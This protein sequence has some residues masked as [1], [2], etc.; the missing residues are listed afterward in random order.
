MDQQPLSS[1]WS[2]IASVAIVVFPVV[3]TVL[4]IFLV[5]RRIRAD[6]ERNA[7]KCAECREIERVIRA[8]E[9]QRRWTEPFNGE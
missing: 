7:L 2:I 8:R 1:K 4:N 5:R 9:L 3:N 6:K